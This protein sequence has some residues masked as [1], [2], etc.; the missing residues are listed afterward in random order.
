MGLLV[1]QLSGDHRPLST[2]TLVGRNPMCGLHVADSRVSGEHAALSWNGERW[3][4]RDLG[5][6]NGT[7]VDGARLSPG[8][9]A[10]LRLNG[11]VAFGA[12]SLAWR[13]C[14]A[15]PPQ[16]RALCSERGLQ[17]TEEGGVLL[18]PDDEAP[19]WSVS[20]QGAGW[21][22][23][24]LEGARPVGNGDVLRAGGA[25]W[26]LML[27]TP[28]APTSQADDGLM[29]LAFRVSADE[30]T[31]EIDLLAGQRRQLVPSQSFSYLLLTL[32]RQRAADAAL[33]LDQ[34]GW[35]DAGE[36]ARM[37]RLSTSTVNVYVHRAR[38][39]FGRLSATLGPSL[40]ERRTG[41]GQLRL[42]L[43]VA[44]IEALG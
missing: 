36:L 28:L 3:S 12:A 42:G 14:E 16:A 18:L 17:R 11:E 31:V 24:G 39:A 29:A 6:R 22:A 38:K 7:W 1:S 4:V 9:E 27:P 13:L 20:V 32:G 30:E 25:T 33:P 21:L 5:S 2:R 15:G 19:E 40:I 10:E 35:V 23:E 41:S 8:Q 43:P 26:R 34:Q 37:L 44:G